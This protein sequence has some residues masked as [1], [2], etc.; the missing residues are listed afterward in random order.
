MPRNAAA[1]PDQ[2][3]SGI[4]IHVIDMVQPPGIGIPPIADMVVQP[5]TVVTALAAKSSAATPRNAWLEARVP[6]DEIAGPSMM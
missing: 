6:R 1:V 2:L 3:W 4:R 5:T